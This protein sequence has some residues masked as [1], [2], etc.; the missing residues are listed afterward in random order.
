MP[1]I[2]EFGAKIAAV[3]GHNRGAAHNA[4]MTKTEILEW[5]DLSAGYMSR[6]YGQSRAEVTP[7][8]ER[9]IVMAL[10]FGPVDVN[11]E[12][13]WELAWRSWLTEWRDTWREG[14][15]ADLVKRLETTSC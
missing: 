3:C 11:L 14:S 10:G 5:L 13:N 15:P 4:P 2:H 7:V 12:K 9:A 8:I 1:T 6:F